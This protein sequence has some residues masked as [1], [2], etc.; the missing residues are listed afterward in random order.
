MG[1]Q[2]L[3]ARAGGRRLNPLQFWVGSFGV[4]VV[5]LAVGHARDRHRRS[6]PSC[7]RSRLRRSHVRSSRGVA[8]RRLREVQA[9]WPDGLRDLV[10][11]IAAGRS[12]S[13]RWSSSRRP[14]PAPLRAAFAAFRVSRAHARHASPRSKSFGRSSPTPPATACIEVL[15]LASERGGQIVK[16]ILEDLVV[17]TTKDLKV[18]DEIDTEGLE[19]RINA[20]AVLVLP[21]FV[22]VALTLRGGAF[23]E[24][25]ASSA[26]LLVVLIGGALSAIGYVWISHLGRSQQ[27]HRVLGSGRISVSSGSVT[28]RRCWLVVAVGGAGL[29][30]AGAAALVVRPLPRLGP[31][32]RPYTVVARARHAATPTSPPWSPPPPLSPGGTLPA[33]VRAA[34]ARVR[35]APRPHR[36][37]PRRRCARALAA[38]SRV[39][40]RVARRLPHPGRHPTA[41]LRCCRRGVRDRRAPLDA[42]ARSGSRCA[43]R[44]SAC[45]V[46]VVG[47]TGRSAIAPSASDS[48]STP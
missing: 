15:I 34:V 47:S 13:G 14:D 29:A 6:S 46:H 44:C 43:V 19:M 21:W 25:Y 9:A 20:R 37:T 41:V 26:G 12:L 45:R 48:S 4:G 2:Q 32:V 24:F 42:R 17:A 30:A 18:L 38:P 36:G 7:P 23:R 27:E 16:E 5:A 35:G 28:E 40:R 11:S 10:S 33:P 1:S 31:R 22:L 39:C 3:L 8:R